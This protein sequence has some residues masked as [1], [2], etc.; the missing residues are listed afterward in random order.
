MVEEEAVDEEVVKAGRRYI[1]SL[2]S[3]RSAITML[4]P[5]SKPFIPARILIE[6]G[7]K[8]DKANM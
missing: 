5:T 1:A 7:A 6:F 3:M 2:P 4:C 8:M